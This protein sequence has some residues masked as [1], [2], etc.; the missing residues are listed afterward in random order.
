MRLEAEK[1]RKR[2]AVVIP[3]VNGSIIWIKQIITNMYNRLYFQVEEQ[4][5]KPKPSGETSLTDISDKSSP[6]ESLIEQPD[7]YESSSETVV[8]DCDSLSNSSSQ[9]FLLDDLTHRYRK[10]TRG[11][12]RG[13]PRGSKRGH[14]GGLSRPGPSSRIDTQSGVDTDSSTNNIESSPIRRGPGRP[15]LKPN[16]P[17]NQVHR[18]GLAP[19]YRKPMAPLV[20]PLGVSPAPTPTIRSPAMSPAMS[21]ERL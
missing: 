14:R 9:T 12:K 17:S 15:R 18:V 16:G 6:A 13:R 3:K 5:K 2:K 10:P 8:V 1:E 11:G 4:C 21:P 20:V 19:K 7:H